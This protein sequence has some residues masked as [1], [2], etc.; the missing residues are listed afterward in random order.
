[1]Y[2]P[3]CSAELPHSAGGNERNVYSYQVW[4]ST[5]WAGYERVGCVYC[6][7]SS[8]CLYETLQCAT[9]TIRL[10]YTM[11][12]I[13]IPTNYTVRQLKTSTTPSRGP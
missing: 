5:A 4:F 6:M 10:M 1:V 11:L 13:S 8:S 9:T 3:R 12:T 7:Q 2:A